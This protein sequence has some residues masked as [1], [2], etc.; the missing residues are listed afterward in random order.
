FLGQCQKGSWVW[1]NVPISR[2]S[3]SE[4]LNLM[5]LTASVSYATARVPTR[6]SLKNKEQHDEIVQQQH[7]FS[8]RD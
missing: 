8:C 4:F 2:N 7:E 5:T 6:G 3:R 1:D